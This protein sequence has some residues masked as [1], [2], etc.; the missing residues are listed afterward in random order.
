MRWWLLIALSV[1]Q[2]AAAGPERQVQ[3][4]VVLVAIRASEVE[5]D[6]DLIPT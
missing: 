5:V 2:V 6:L 3:A 4:V 1:S